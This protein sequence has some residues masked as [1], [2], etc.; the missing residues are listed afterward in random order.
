MTIKRFVHYTRP[1]LITDLATQLK[2]SHLYELIAAAFGYGSYASLQAEAILLHQTPWTSQP[3]L[4]LLEQ[5][6]LELEHTNANKL[7]LLLAQHLQLAGVCCIRVDE[8]ETPDNFDRVRQRS[9]AVDELERLLEDEPDTPLAQQAIKQLGEFADRGHPDVHWLL[10]QKLEY[11]VED[12]ETIDDYWYRQKQQGVELSGAARAFAE[13]SEHQQQVNQQWL[14]HASKAA[15]EGVIDALCALA[16]TRND[17]R[18]FCVEPT[19]IGDL[20]SIARLAEDQENWVEAHRWFTLAAERGDTDAMEQLILEQDAGDTYRCWV[21]LLLSKKCGVDLSK[22][23]HRAYHENGDAYDDDVGGLLI[24]GG[25][26]AIELPVLP[27][28]LANQAEQEAERLYREGS[29]RTL[30]NDE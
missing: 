27:G 7:A 20:A 22:S 11:F 8:I 1:R 17:E 16:S 4:P 14:Y 6:G 9:F 30:E 23:D 21:W 15:D 13:E 3:D 19:K 12:S 18:I 5:R 2:V 26:D 29:G 10:A 28:E 25:R 24:I